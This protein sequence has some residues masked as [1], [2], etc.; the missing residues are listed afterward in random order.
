MP[1]REFDKSIQRKAN[2][3]RLEPSPEVW[4]KVA[5][6]IK[7]KDRRRGFAWYWLAAA[8]LAGGLSIWFLSPDLFNKSVPT[9]VTQTTINDSNATPSVSNSLEN[10]KNNN[11][12]ASA[13]QERPAKEETVS[14][15]NGDPLKSSQPVITANKKSENTSFST[16]TKSKNPTSPEKRIAP[17]DNA[18]YAIK[19]Q[20]QQQ[21]QLAKVQKDKK[22][23]KTAIAT[24][25]TE[26]PTQSPA[27]V[28]ATEKEL[29]GKTI[30]GN[31]NAPEP[32]EIEP[33][34]ATAGDTKLN[35]DLLAAVAKPSKTKEPWNLAM[36]IG[37]GS[38]SMRDGLTSAYSPVAENFSGNIALQ[39]PG[40]ATTLDPRPSDVKAGPSFQA[41]IGVSKP[42][43]RKLNFITGLQY[44][45]FSNRIE[46]G[47]KMDSSALF[48]N[49]RLQNI[50]ATTAYTGAGNEGKAYYNAYHYLQVPV[51]IGWY[52]D[53]RKRFSWNNG[54][55]F[56]ILLRTDA[57]HYDQAAGAYYQNN[58]L[59]N[60]FQT[61]AQT[62]LNYRLFNLGSG[63]L[64]AGPFLNYQLSNIDKTAGNKRLLTVGLNARFLFNKQK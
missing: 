12:I 62:S 46:V 35:A 29:F 41:S 2:E 18:S 51:E 26:Q 61:S 33:N 57:L 10:N 23:E 28:E 53:N 49:F 9:T 7:E 40:T 15:A 27:I 52:L 16:E 47:R 5:A 11:D 22:T 64:S 59:V 44:A 60:K 4:E 43:S 37:G 13:Q 8:M 50:A 32:G 55:L 36:Q 58:D 48:S 20:G 34:D 30:A 56:G 19:A 21:R 42:I 39:P 54:F 63:N 1:D 17:T 25:P 14:V 24:E 38:G 3:L 45:Y 6:Q 31:N